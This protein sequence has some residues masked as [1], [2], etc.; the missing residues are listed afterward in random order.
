[1]TKNNKQTN[2][3]TVAPSFHLQIRLNNTHTQ[4]SWNEPFT[5]PRNTSVTENCTL[6]PSPFT[7]TRPEPPTTR[8]AGEATSVPSWAYIIIGVGG[9][10]LPVLLCCIFVSIFLCRN[11]K[12]KKK[13]KNLLKVT[14]EVS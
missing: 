3:Q 1:M 14:M 9:G 6:V 2:K 7:S 4:G 5:V 13:W 10:L 8:S 11:Q 12:R